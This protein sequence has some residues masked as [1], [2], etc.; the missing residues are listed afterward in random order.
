MSA[1]SMAMTHPRL[2]LITRP[3]LT[4]MKCKSSV[5]GPLTAPTGKVPDSQPDTGM[6]L[7]GMYH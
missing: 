3:K 2:K 1:T 6:Y 7:Y 5:H 4:L